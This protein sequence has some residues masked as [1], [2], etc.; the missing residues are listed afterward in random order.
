MEHP[1]HRTSDDA[2]TTRSTSDEQQ[3]ST[4]NAVDQLP[5]DPEG[6]IELPR[7]YDEAPMDALVELIADMLQRLITHNDQIPLS[8]EALTRFHSRTPPAISVL[9]YLRRIV[10]YANVEV[11]LV[12]FQQISYILSLRLM[13][14]YMP[15]YHSSLHRSALCSDAALHALVSHRTSL[16]YRCGCR[17]IQGLMRWFLHKRS[18]RS[19]WWNSSWRTQRPRAGA[20]VGYRLAVDCMCLLYVL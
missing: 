15:T 10:K 1:S 20:L 16:C 8:P 18:L 6:R 13:T 11:S 4:A 19:C 7:G 12:L 9:D 14:A 17:G 2:A 3:Q 5:R